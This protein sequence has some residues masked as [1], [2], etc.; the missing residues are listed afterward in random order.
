[1]PS[2]P[3]TAPGR[4]RTLSPPPPRPPPPAGG[5]GG[6]NISYSASILQSQTI[7]SADSTIQVMR[8]VARLKTV[9]LAFST[10]DGDSDKINTTQFYHPA[11]TDN[12]SPEEF[13]MQVG[14]V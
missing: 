8:N 3:K 13:F 10:T 5:G 2:G 4:G 12:Q 6:L 11:L 1:M 14:G 9:F 7:V